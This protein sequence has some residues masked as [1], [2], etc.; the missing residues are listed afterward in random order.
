VPLTFSGSALTG[1]VLCDAF[2]HLHHPLR[3]IVRDLNSANGVY[4]KHHRVKE[5]KPL[6]DGDELQVR[7]SFAVNAH[8]QPHSLA[9]P[10]AL[11]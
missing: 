11:G 10:S 7:L 2:L 9:I 1:L 6:K 8:A 5:K 4:V 3:Y